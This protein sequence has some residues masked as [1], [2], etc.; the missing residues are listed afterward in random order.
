MI[1]EQ[2]HTAKQ[3]HAYLLVSCTSLPSK[4][5]RLLPCS[6][7]G[8]GPSNQ[9]GCSE[10]DPRWGA[11]HIEGLLKEVAS[12]YPGLNCQ[13]EKTVAWNASIR[14]VWLYL[15][16]VWW[17]LS[18]IQ[19]GT[20]KGIWT[21]SGQIED[22]WQ[23]GGGIRKCRGFLLKRLPCPGI[24]LVSEYPVAHHQ[25]RSKRTKNKRM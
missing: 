6:Q 5:S 24:Q 16:G 9:L 7:A 1:C 11:C 18:S 12:I 21:S 13:G 25:K 17:S 2:K 8:Q 3:S 15:R 4:C 19:S 23:F 20:Q 10:V 22:I 14:R